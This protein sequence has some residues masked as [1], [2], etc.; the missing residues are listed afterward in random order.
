[1]QHR[2]QR[3]ILM[4][5]DYRADNPYQQLLVDGLEQEEVNV[6]FPHGYRRILPI[7]R[8]AMD[9]R[10]KPDVIHLHWLSPYAKGSNLATAFLYR[11][12]LLLDIAL[13]RLLGFRLVWTIHN[14]KPHESKWPRLDK[15][16][17]RRLIGLANRAIVHSHGAQTEACREYL[18][19]PEKIVVIPHGHFRDFYGAPADRNKARETLSLPQDA[20]L[21]LF[22]GMIRPYKGVERLLSLWNAGRGGSILLVAGKPADETMR[23]EIGKLGTQANVRLILRRIDDAEIP[24]L[25]SAADV[26]VFPFADIL[27]SGSVALAMS[28]DVPVIAP[29]LPGIAEILAGADELLYDPNQPDG[30]EKAI[31]KAGKM[32]LLPMRER[33]RMACDGLS[34]EMIA[35]KTKKCYA[36]VNV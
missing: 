35:R 16:L 3:H 7:T 33:T 28:Y 18:C 27:T 30:L 19:R 31:D 11:A 23:E 34:W 22:F 20:R 12:K 8:A 21:F 4:L 29:R 13:A 6:E 1:M 10:H 17:R 36:S 9:C 26:A 5:P 15:W 24:L 25:F 2:A 32:E 14:L